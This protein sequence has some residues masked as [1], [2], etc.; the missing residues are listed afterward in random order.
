MS[1]AEVHHLKRRMHAG[2][3]QK[4][5]RGALHHPLPVGLTRQR[6][7]SVILNPDAEV[8]ARLRLIFAKFAELGSA[9]A[10]RTYLAQEQLL[11]PA[12]PPRGP[13]RMTRS[14]RSPRAAPFYASCTT[15]RM[16]ARRSMGNARLIRRDSASANSR[17]N[18]GRFASRMSTRPTSVGRRIWLIANACRRIAT[19]ISVT[20]T[21]CPVRAKPCCRGLSSVGAAGD[22]WAWGTRAPTAIIR[23]TAVLPMRATTGERAVKK[24]VVQASTLRSSS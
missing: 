1:E 24:S 18:S 7:G 8:Q 23:S 12:R 13:A 3:R 19:S 6:D 4:A 21:A 2:A 14:G 16:R 10:V 17:L 9:R 11:I 15:P 5:E 22:I 20:V